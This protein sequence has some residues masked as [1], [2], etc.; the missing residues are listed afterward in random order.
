MNNTP[1]LTPDPV[2][3]P[4]L[5]LAAE[6][7]CAQIRRS[8]RDLPVASPTWVAWSAINNQLSDLHDLRR[9]AYRPGVDRI[10]RIEQ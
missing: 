4:L 10:R 5:L 9:A 6:R 7:L 3:E 1:P 2:A 8:L